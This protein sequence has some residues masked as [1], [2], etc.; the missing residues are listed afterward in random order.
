MT[1]LLTYCI[2]DAA[3]ME[4]NI[5]RAKEINGEFISLF[6]NYFG[7]A[8]LDS[9]SPYIFSFEL[10]SNFSSW[11]FENGWSK[12]WGM[13]A[14]S[15]SSINTLHRHFSSLLSV[16][17]E[18]NEELYFRFYD[19]RVLRVF[20]PT[21]DAQQL[22]QFFGPVDYFVCED[23]NPENGIIFSLSNGELISKIITKKEVQSLKL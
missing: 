15:D 7:E 4:V 10:L 16:K 2:L 23:E 13:F 18:N 3:R 5:L 19:P 14:F 20:L 21:C 9:V 22:Q 8:S 6:K 17:T 1:K 11:Y 12:S